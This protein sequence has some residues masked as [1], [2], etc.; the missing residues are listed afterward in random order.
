MLSKTDDRNPRAS[1]VGHDAEGSFSTGM[2]DAHSTS[3][4]RKMLTLKA[5]GIRLHC[6]CRRG[7]QA[8]IATHTATPMKGNT[9][10]KC[11]NFRLTVTLV[12][13]A[14]TRMAATMKMRAQSIAAPCPF[15]AAS[16]E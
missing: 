8:K 7:T 15:A 4:S 13:I 2:R 3:A 14:A 6:G 10:A 5:S 11:L 9:S 16:G 12:A 1:E